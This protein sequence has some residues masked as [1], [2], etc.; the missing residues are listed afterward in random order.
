MY[1]EMCAQERSRRVTPALL[2]LLILLRP[3]GAAAL[4]TISCEGTNECKDDTRTC[5][6][7]EDCAL[8]CSGLFA[9]YGLTVTA[10]TGRTLSIVCAGGS[11]Y[12]CANMKVHAETAASVAFACAS[13]TDFCGY[14]ASIFCPACDQDTG[15]GCPPSTASTTPIGGGGDPSAVCAVSCTATGDGQAHTCKQLDVYPGPDGAAVTCAEDGTS[16]S[17]WTCRD[18]Q[19]HAPADAGAAALAPLSIGCMDC[20]GRASGCN[21]YC[22]CCDGAEVTPA[23]SCPA[24]DGAGAPGRDVACGLHWA[25]CANSPRCV[26]AGL[27]SGTCCPSEGSGEYAACCDNTRRPTGSPTRYPTEESGTIN[28]YGNYACTNGQEYNEVKSCPDGEDC[29]LNC[30][31]KNAC[32]GL[33]I[34]G[35]PAPHVLAISCAGPG[36]LTCHELTV[37]AERAAGVTFSCT[38]TVHNCGQSAAV[39]CPGCDFVAQRADDDECSAGGNAGGTC[40]VSCTGKG[41]KQSTCEGLTVYAGRAGADVDCIENGANSKYT[42][43]G[44]EL[45]APE[46]AAAAAAAP[47]TL[48]CA[49]CGGSGCCDGAAV[50]PGA[51]CPAGSG[52]VGNGASVM[53]GSDFAQCARQPRCVDTGFTAGT[54]CPSAGTGEY[55]A[56]C[57][58]TAAPTTPTKAPT[59]WPSAPTTQAPTTFAPTQAPTTESTAS[60]S[61]AAPTGH[62]S[63]RPTAFPSTKRPTAFPSK[64]PTKYPT[65]KQPTGFPVP[66]GTKY[67]VPGG[68]KYPTTKWPTKPVHF[69]HV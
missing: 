34:H 53:C 63:K 41:N 49:A 19:V 59:S 43:K 67:P 10:P 47:L 30:W 4:H 58:N 45:R 62:P 24:G 35:P 52:A 32:K 21:P 61:T 68:T 60:P 3:H 25:Q 13:S 15:G 18:L 28:C 29:A 50:A 17:K 55:D 2:L 20:A 31:G 37:H 38:A 36:L 51:S 48:S 44:L 12:V 16:D 14:G 5:P 7:G 33:T 56:C 64:A 9:C 22:G 27:T 1:S 6:A 66:G 26:D 69:V 11:K 46:D 42:C 39:F 57:D 40:A 8:T 23:H 54:C 65:T